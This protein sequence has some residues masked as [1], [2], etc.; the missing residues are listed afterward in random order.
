MQPE[1]PVISK[2]P[3]NSSRANTWWIYLRELFKDLHSS[4]R[5]I[6][7]KPV[8]ACIIDKVLD[9]LFIVDCPR[10]NF[11]IHSVRFFYIVAVCDGVEVL[12]ANLR[13]VGLR[14]ARRRDLSPERLDRLEGITVILLV[15]V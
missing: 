15:G 7:D 3:A 11:D 12:V 6:G 4:F 13:V 2:R 1:L 10:E 5:V 8:D 14:I 9:G